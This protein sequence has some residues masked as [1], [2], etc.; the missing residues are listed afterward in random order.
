M[1]LAQWGTGTRWINTNYPI[2]IENNDRYLATALSPTDPLKHES[3][4]ISRAPMSGAQLE[5]MIL[6][7]AGLPCKAGRW[8]N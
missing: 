3:N 1:V 6:K 5:P 8:C 7:D 4:R 2:R